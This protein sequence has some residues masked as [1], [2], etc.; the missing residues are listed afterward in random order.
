MEHAAHTQKS[1]IKEDDSKSILN[2]NNILGK[3]RNISAVSQKHEGY[4]PFWTPIQ[5]WIK[6]ENLKLWPQDST[7]HY[8]VN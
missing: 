3:E 8:R 1:N 6:P 2:S 7:P 5:N 4:T